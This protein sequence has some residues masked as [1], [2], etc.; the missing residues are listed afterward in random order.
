MWKLGDP[1]PHRRCVLSVFH[2]RSFISWKLTPPTSTVEIANLPFVDD[3]LCL[4]QSAIDS[5]YCLALG[6]SSLSD[7][8]KS[9]YVDTLVELSTRVLQTAQTDGS[10]LS[11]QAKNNTKAILYFLSAAASKIEASC[12]GDASALP[13]SS[14]PSKG[15]TANGDDDGDDNDEDEDGDFG[16][17]S[18]GRKTAKAGAKASKA[19]APKG[20]RKGGKAASKAS[21]GDFSWVDYRP[22][23]L[24]LI[25]KAVSLEPSV[26]W[27]MGVVPES[28][29]AASW[30]FALELLET[31][32]AGVAGAGGAEARTRATCQQI[33]STC[34]GNFASSA[35]SCGYAALS[36]SILDALLRSE[37]F[38]SSAAE[39]C[40]HCPQGLLS[41]LFGEVSRMNLA[42]LPAGGVK[43][44]G[45]F[46]EALAKVNPQLMTA[47]LPVV[48]KQLDSG[49]HQIRS[50]LLQ[51]IGVVVQHI[52]KVVTTAAQTG[53]SLA[54][55][56]GLGEEEIPAPASTRTAGGE[57]EDEEESDD[58]AAAAAAAARD[59]QDFRKNPSLLPRVRDSLLDVL[60]E[61]THDVS[62]YSRAA[63]L[64]V[65]QSLLEADAVPARRVGSVAEIAV[66]RLQDKAAAVRK[67]SLS[68]LTAVVDLNP[69]GGVLDKAY[70]ETEKAKAEAALMARVVELKSM[71]T[72][73]A[74]EVADAVEELNA[75]RGRGRTASA[76]PAVMEDEDEDAD[77][78]ILDVADTMLPPAV[79]AAAVSARGSGSDAETVAAIVTQL[80]EDDP[81]WQS[82]DVAD[83]VQVKELKAKIDFSTSALELVAAVTLAMPRVNS[84]VLSKTAGDVVEAMRFLA[85]AVNFHVQG[86][87]RAFQKTFSLAFHSDAAIRGECLEAF[88]N[89]FLTDGA[90][91]H[92]L[93]LPAA[94]VAL[95]LLSVVRSC[96]A[97]ATA[98]LEE[99]IGALFKEKAVDPAVIACLWGK[100]QA[101]IDA[102]Q[103]PHHPAAIESAAA[104]RVL[105]IIA[106]HSNIVTAAKIRMLSQTP[107]LGAA[108]QQGFCTD[109]AAMRGACQVLLRGPAA[110]ALLSASA[111]GQEG[112]RDFYSAIL[113]CVPGLV[114]ILSGAMCGDDEELTRQWFSAAEEAT[115]ALF[116]V[117]PCPDK[118][119]ASVI[120]PMFAA[121]FPAAPAAGAEAAGAGERVG[122]SAARLSR[123]LFVLGQ[124]SLSGLVYA[125]RLAH[126]AKQAS[127]SSSAA[128]S[129]AAAAA[130]TVVAAEA[131]A[132]AA[133]P[134]TKA[135]GKKSKKDAS[136]AA[137]EAAA[138]AANTATDT[139]LEDEMGMAAAADA[140]S[141]RV[142]TL[143]TERELVVS[144]SNLLGRFHHVVA[145]VVAN[146]SGAFSSPLVREAGLLALCR[147]MSVSSVL[148]EQYLPLLFTVLERE[149][150]EACRTTMMIALGD[151]A[152]RFPNSLD[153]WTP[154]MYARLSDDRVLV[155]YNALMVLTHLILNDMVKVKGHVAHV[156]LC[157]S[158][159]EERVRELA[160]LFFNKLSERSNNPIYNL[161]GD[162]IGN[163]SSSAAKQPAAGA[164]AGDEQA[165]LPPSSSSAALFAGPAV[166]V[167][168]LE[169]AAAPKRTLSGA[170]FQK[171]MSFLLTFVKKDKQADGMLER[172]LGRLAMAQSL[173]QR[174]CLAYCMSEL[175]ITD[176]G[177][178][179]LAESTKVSLPSPLSS[180]L[181]SSLLF[182]SSLLPLVYSLSLTVSHLPPPLSLSSHSQAIKDALY[183][184]ETFEFISTAVSKAKKASKAVGASAEGKDIIADFEQVLEAIR[185]DARGDEVN[186]LADKCGAAAAAS[187][188]G[189]EGEGAE[190]NAEPE[191]TLRKPKA[192]P[193]KKAAAPKKAAACK[194]KK[195]KKA[196]DSDDDD[197]G[198]DDDDEEDV[199]PKSRA[200]P[201]SKAASS[202]P[203]RGA[204]KVLREVN[205]D[206]EEAEF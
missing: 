191:M 82:A 195:S 74:D 107:A 110:T 193:A 106:A 14:A 1:R 124:A 185:R 205:A 125:E 28:F 117:H 91:D 147:F 187:G 171:T 96:D 128:A 179:K 132:A 70:F 20:G 129:A 42:A 37:P 4:S 130:A 62:P 108:T 115:H 166:S 120:V 194:A 18:K 15:R 29:L 170:E 69:F 57:D 77:K 201:A 138:P 203:Q 131:E 46:I 168:A 59:D 53:M 165:V 48:M 141:D 97:A 40:S 19:A 51:A 142:F 145:F 94:E 198:G 84:M 35:T 88:K 61:R 8:L 99:I 6:F 155:R 161:L 75:A 126:L 30:S 43:N 150:N 121:L 173:R 146:Q 33:I 114:S 67:A 156:V 41:E 38:A 202:R 100:V 24:D 181:F 164:G 78:T 2:L 148:C 158:D 60:V 163:L 85:R 80:K 162:I 32:P 197:D 157:L 26:L 183:D 140:E 47:Q 190:E 54:A 149:E 63:V 56:S 136:S 68:L 71:A 13:S 127:S 123:L 64:K 177:V 180:C 65:W 52:H 72:P 23:V 167:A 189:A 66:D 152:F 135:K 144:P 186:A 81:F 153:A 31:R 21:E 27:A 58:A 7:E 90:V 3:C 86:A 44:I 154:L 55:V 109:F 25:L 204:R 133:A 76:L 36:T 143:L 169:S 111:S 175:N 174:R 188:A 184:E 159:S 92:P 139:N 176:K 10:A 49:A 113:E 104:M 98:S 39:I 199:K 206:E 122:V 83:D 5:L 160:T 119:I 200:A 105:A 22:L 196:R 93:P 34:T 116:H 12:R 118:V 192:A 95:N 79:A 172:L 11:L 89:V 134:T 182:L 9:A 178:K 151:L 45:A 87:V 103:S 112:K 73:S 16:A 50:S 137:G 17:P 102:P 101:S